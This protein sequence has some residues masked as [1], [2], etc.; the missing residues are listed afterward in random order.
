[1]DIL[2]ARDEIMDGLARSQR[3]LDEANRIFTE[4]ETRA[5][6]RM[7]IKQLPPVARK[8][9]KRLAPKGYKMLAESEG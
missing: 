4:P 1:M 8:E 7:F 3:M 6:M 9:L 5:A 2:Q